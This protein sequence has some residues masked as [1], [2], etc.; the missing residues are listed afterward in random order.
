MKL[1]VAEG[2]LVPGAVVVSSG[3]VEEVVSAVGASVEASVVVA[4]DPALVVG[5][6]CTVVEESSSPASSG[7]E[8]RPQDSAALDTEPP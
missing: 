4:L 8:F 5:A 1:L 7:V 3:W 2:A 6:G